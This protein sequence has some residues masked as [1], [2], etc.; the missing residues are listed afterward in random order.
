MAVY[1]REVVVVL[2]MIGRVHDSWHKPHNCAH[3]YANKT[4]FKRKPKP[5]STGCLCYYK[6][7]IE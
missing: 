7:I 1:N 6:M 5:P 4:R 2:G 3:N